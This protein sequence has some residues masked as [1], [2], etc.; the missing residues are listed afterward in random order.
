MPS[1]PERR[2]TLVEREIGI[3]GTVRSRTWVDAARLHQWLVGRPVT[4]VPSFRPATQALS[5]GESERHYFRF[6]GRAIDLRYLLRLVIY[7]NGASVFKPYSVV[8]PIGGTRYDNRVAFDPEAVPPA[9]YVIAYDLDAAT[10]LETE[11]SF[12][13]GDIDDV[14][15][16]PRIMSVSVETAPRTSLTDNA[17]EFG[18]ERLDFF[19]RQPITVSDLG[20]VLARNN[21]V[22]AASRRVGQWHHSWGDLNPKSTT[23]TSLVDAVAS[24]TFVLNRKLWTDD[25]Y[26][27]LHCRVIAYTSDSTTT[28]EVVI[29]ASETGD[30]VTINIPAAGGGVEQWAPVPWSSPAELFVQVEDP[31]QSDGLPGGAAD[32]ITVQFRRTAGSGTVYLVGI[33]MWEPTENVLSIPPLSGARSNGSAW[34]SDPRD[35]F[36]FEAADDAVD[37]VTA[38][39]PRVFRDGALLNDGDRT[40]LLPDST[41]L[42]DV[43]Y[44]AT[45]TPVR[46]AGGGAPN[47]GT[48]YIYED[49][50]GA[51]TEDY[52]SGT[53]SVTASGTYVASCF[54]KK[55]TTA[56]SYAGL[57]V[58]AN[59]GSE[60]WIYH[61]DAENGALTQESGGTAADDTFVFDA[62]DWWRVGFSFTV[63]G[64]ETG[65][66]FRFEPAKATV[67]G[68][69]STAATGTVEAWGFQVELGDFMSTIIETT[70]AAVRREDETWSFSPA[71]WFLATGFEVTVCTEWGSLNAP[72]NAYVFYAD[73]SNYLVFTSSGGTLRLRANG[74]NYDISLSARDECT[75]L[76]INVDFAGGTM[77]LSGADSGSVGSITDDWTG[78]GATFYVGSFD[79][80]SNSIFGTISRPIAA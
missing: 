53:L 28:G 66:V 51:A 19:P 47:G 43:S 2:L 24:G 6:E 80:G 36:N 63:G 17:T 79:D 25:D 34:M 33:S 12:R 48:S 18:I 62:G 57:R 42:T 60:D 50:D 13:W 26:R 76:T 78:A 7:E 58:V 49:D 29:S 38:Q 5:K 9:E 71:R 15:S 67:L 46:S 69:A 3:G 68:T 59:V 1:V 27:V 65:V 75:E 10:A 56:S 44:S 4:L 22:R 64:T 41:D 73:A 30:S 37:S 54:V 61:I 16:D 23:S 31:T 77:T 74:T 45:G 72:G 8:V 21:E 40:N 52:Y 35:G 14:G 32:E 55:E 39:Q 20:K 70:T 11:F